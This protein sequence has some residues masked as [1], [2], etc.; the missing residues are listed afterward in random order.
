MARAGRSGILRS[1]LRIGRSLAL[2]VAI[3]SGYLG[4]LRML[5][6]FDLCERLR[7]LRVVDPRGPH[8]AITQVETRVATTDTMARA[9]FRRYWAAFSSGILLIRRA[10][11]REV[12]REAERRYHAATRSDGATRP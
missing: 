1:T 7:E 10:M 5:T 11:L 9:R 8:G 12:R 6:R 4:R 3:V 2:W